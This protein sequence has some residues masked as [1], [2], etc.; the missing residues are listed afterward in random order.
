[1]SGED[2]IIGSKQN[3]TETKNT[4]KV[5][6]L[7]IIMWDFLNK[8]VCISMTHFPTESRL[9]IQGKCLVNKGCITAHT[10]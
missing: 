2:I 4:C 6:L 1:M 10:S 3:D 9:Y 5:R 8:H 7:Y